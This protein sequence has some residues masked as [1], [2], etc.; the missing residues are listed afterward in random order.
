M[1]SG[2]GTR[3]RLGRAKGPRGR[4]SLATAVGGLG[5]RS[6]GVA[7]TVASH[8]VPGRAV[9]GKERHLSDVEVAGR[10]LDRASGQ[11]ALATAWKDQCAPRNKRTGAARAEVAKMEPAIGAR[12]SNRGARN[13]KSCRRC[14]SSL[15]GPEMQAE[16]CT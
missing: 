10:R 8:A 7:S 1:W 16:C 4:P 3:P 11:D 5:V 12:G 2:L 14:A 9:D 15:V 6:V 13:D